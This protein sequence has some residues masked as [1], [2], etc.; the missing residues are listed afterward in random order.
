MNK[1]QTI[2]N[3]KDFIDTSFNCMTYDEYEN[4]C[5]GTGTLSVLDNALSQ[6]DSDCTLD[7]NDVAMLAKYCRNKSNEFGKR[8][9]IHQ[10]SQELSNSIIDTFSTQNIGKLK[11]WV[12]TLADTN[13]G[14]TSMDMIT[15]YYTLINQLAK[16]L[17]YT[18]DDLSDLK[19]DYVEQL[20]QQA[21]SIMDGFAEMCV[22]QNVDY[23]DQD[24]WLQWLQ[25]FEELNWQEMRYIN[26]L[27]DDEAKAKY[28]RN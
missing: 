21:D 16:Q 17:R 24:E 9:S 1:E 15:S 2:Q 4:L 22:D 3:I 19:G 11:F 28:K 27:W 7:D 25:G 26:I 6:H 8:F 10:I 23:D 14:Y 5:Y 12:D 13:D 20:Y 18:D